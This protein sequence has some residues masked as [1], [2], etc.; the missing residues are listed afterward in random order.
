MAVHPREWVRQWLD[1]LSDR[2]RGQVMASGGATGLAIA[3]LAWSHGIGFLPRPGA[4][5]PVRQVGLGALLCAG[6]VYGVALIV[7]APIP[8]PDPSEPMASM[9]LEER[10]RSLWIRRFVSGAIGLVVSFMLFR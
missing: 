9:L 6:I 3:V 8:S 1:G 5:F 10:R 4:L 2:T 7:W